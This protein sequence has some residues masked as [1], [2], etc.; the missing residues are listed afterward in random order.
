MVTFRTPLRTHR[1]PTGGSSQMAT[2]TKCYMR[3][4]LSTRAFPS[5]SCVCAVISTPGRRS[6]IGIRDFRGGSGRGYLIRGTCQDCRLGFASMCEDPKRTLYLLR[7]SIGL[8]DYGF[9]YP[10]HA[11]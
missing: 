6:L 9:S 11:P 1:A 10:P 7:I 4:A 3:M 5:L 2:G 8:A